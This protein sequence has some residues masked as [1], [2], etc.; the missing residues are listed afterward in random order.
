MYV[1]DIMHMAL[2]SND[3]RNVAYLNWDGNSWILN[4]NWLDN[5]FNGNALLVRARNFLWNEKLLYC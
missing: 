2:N 3:N 5:D 4:W 1:D